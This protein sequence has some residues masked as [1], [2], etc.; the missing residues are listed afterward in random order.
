[1]YKNGSKT[2]TSNN[3]FKETIESFS[4][5]GLVGLLSRL[6]NAFAEASFI[7]LNFFI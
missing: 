5:N 2:G 3:V 7:H 1:M 6:I 4:C